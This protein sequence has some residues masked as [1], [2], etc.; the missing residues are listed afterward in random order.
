MFGKNLI[1]RPR[2][3]CDKACRDAHKR[4][5]DAIRWV[6]RA[7]GGTHVSELTV[8]EEFALARKQRKARM[9][10]VTDAAR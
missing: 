9:E 3:Y 10:G 5:L 2:V 1:G 6:E 4:A 7:M 8:G